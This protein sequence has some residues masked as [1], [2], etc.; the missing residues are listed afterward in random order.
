MLTVHGLTPPPG[1][2]R[3]VYEVWLVPAHGAPVAAAF[4]TEQ[5]SSA[6]WT[7]VIDGDVTR[8]RML[9]ATVEPAGGSR[10]PT[11]TEVFSADLTRS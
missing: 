6:T 2:G 3:S 9:A 5:P 1:S 11:G 10:G 4:I 7:A 8:Y